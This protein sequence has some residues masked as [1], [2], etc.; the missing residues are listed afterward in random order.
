MGCGLGC[1]APPVHGEGGECYAITDCQPGLA[2]ADGRCTSDVSKLSG[3]KA[4]PFTMV[5]D[6]AVNDAEMGADSSIADAAPTPDAASHDASTQDAGAQDAS[7]T[8]AG[9][10]DGG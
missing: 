4:P 6:S 3:G 7:T 8:D 2:C 9:T 10:T 5:A 1:S